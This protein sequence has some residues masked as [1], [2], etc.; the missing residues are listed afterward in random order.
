MKSGKTEHSGEHSGKR[1]GFFTLVELLVVI[2]IIA[3]LAALLL[4]ALNASREK[5]QSVKCLGN[6][7][8]LGTASLSYLSDNND[9]FPGAH[10]L[11]E[12]IFYIAPQ[13]SDTVLT[14]SKE[15]IYAPVY[16]CPSPVYPKKNLSNFLIQDHYTISGSFGEFPE[17][18]T[19]F[20]RMFFAFPINTHYHAKATMVKLPSKKI[21][22]TEDGLSQNAESKDGICNFDNIYAANN[23]RAAR[24]HGKLGNLCRADGGAMSLRLPEFLFTTSAY[25][26][27]DS[28]DVN[29]FTSNLVPTKEL[30]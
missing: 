13:L 18:I 5:A 22:L 26:P 30:F 19:E 7:K 12:T 28:Y 14:A 3:I 17:T 16:L 20:T 25:Y 23:A 6:M 8:Q 21:Y 29:R 1:R 27:D 4:P 11:K 15:K 2:S 10:W 9:Y 24:M